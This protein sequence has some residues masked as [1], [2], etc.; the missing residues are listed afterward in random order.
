MLQ[1]VK[2]ASS[3]MIGSWN[4]ATWCD[5]RC[6]RRARNDLLPAELPIIIHHIRHLDTLSA[7]IRLLSAR[8]LSGLFNPTFF[9]N[10]CE[11]RLVSKL[12]F[13][14]LPLKLSWEHLLWVIIVATIGADK[15]PL[16]IAWLCKVCSNA[17]STTLQRFAP[18]FY[19]ATEGNTCPLTR[20]GPV[21]R[22]KVYHSYNINAFS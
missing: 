5:Y 22:F 13:T 20:H 4:S 7:V 16:I 10:A 17:T 8:I 9:I 12:L 14:E 3:D 21:T 19:S 6:I 1:R 11:I 18:R 15:W 2:M